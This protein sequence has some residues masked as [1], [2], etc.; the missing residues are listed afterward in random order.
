MSSPDFY[1]AEQL[2]EPL[3]NS[4]LNYDYDQTPAQFFAQV[5]HERSS[6]NCKVVAHQFSRDV[7][8][9]EKPPELQKAEAYFN[10]ETEHAPLRRG[11]PTEELRLGDWI[12]Y[13]RP[14]TVHPRLVPPRYDTTGVLLNWQEL[15]L[16]HQGVYLGKHHGQPMI[17][18]ATPATGVTISPQREILHDRRTT[19]IYEVLRLKSVEQTRHAG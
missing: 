13:G 2:A 19:K 8:G 7:L 12:I 17:L 15:A 3:L 18:H 1:A 5:E 16:N 14:S 4:G 9:V 10:S 11:H 6:T